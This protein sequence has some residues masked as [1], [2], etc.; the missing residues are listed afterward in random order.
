L[1]Y[2][3][4]RQHVIYLLMLVGSAFGLRI[5]LAASSWP[6]LNSD[7]GT[8]GIMALHIQQGARPVFFYGQAYMG[9]L[10]A[11]VAAFLFSF[12]GAGPFAL[13]LAILLF[14]AAFLVA[15]YALTRMLYA[16]RFA[17]FVVLLLGLGSNAVFSRQL[18]AIGGYSETVFFSALAFA[19]VAWL[20]ISIP[21]PTIRSRLLRLCAYCVWGF[22]IGLGLWSD[23]LILP[24]VVC[25]AL[26]LLFF[27]WREL[28]KG[29]IVPLLVCL[30]IGALPLITY[31]LHAPHGSDSWSVLMSQR[32]SINHALPTLLAQIN[33]T[34][35][36][37]IP[38]ATASPLCHH[39]E[40]QFLFYL[41][42]QASHPMDNT[43]TV[44][45]I[46]WSGAYLALFALASLMIILA[47][48][49]VIRSRFRRSWMPQERSVFVRNAMRLCIVLSALLTLYLYTT[50]QAPLTL[51]SILSR[52]LICL[53]IST[54]V[55][56]WPLWKGM[57]WISK[58]PSKAIVGV[59]LVARTFCLSTLVC[60]CIA[61]LYGTYITVSET[62]AA[63]NAARM[64]NVVV[65]T[66]IKD[67]ITHVYSGYWTC[68]RI[69][70]ESRDRITCAVANDNLTGPGFNRYPQYYEIVRKDP[71]AAY[72]FERNNGFL[73]FHP[74]DLTVIEKKLAL[75][76]KQ[77]RRLL[78]EDYVV[79]EPVP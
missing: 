62:P 29:F 5:F 72:I 3:K 46:M 14:Y 6:L 17:L 78:I 19:L 36:Y 61:L 37:S 16:K 20:A 35:A 55:V 76:G 18:S 66:L 58:Q 26:F 44:D 73:Y 51:P 71:H 47:L 52:Y 27:C 39:S 49:L 60:L 65:N 54:P 34:I 40:Y 75:T 57:T 45:G 21:V 12:F 9:A 43:C 10:Q 7:E 8:I 11:Y 32:G 53:W 23:L 70:F 38:A 1:K 67:K 64:E 56:I 50:S 74:S 31:N 30:V 69:A 42:F 2:L 13:R 24:V 68:D 28:L 25:S 33:A 59:N 15:M 77:Y 22:A 63:V 48:F 41:G 4:R 79:Y